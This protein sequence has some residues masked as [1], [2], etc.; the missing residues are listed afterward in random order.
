MLTIRWIYK[1]S[2]STGV[3]G[4]LP[5]ATRNL[6]SIQRRSGTLGGRGGGGVV[7]IGVRAVCPTSVMLTK[8]SSS[9]KAKWKELF[10]C[11]FLSHWASSLAERSSCWSQ[12]HVLDHGHILQRVW[13]GSLVK[14]RRQS[15][16]MHSWLYY[17][18]IHDLEQVIKQL[19]ALN[20][21]L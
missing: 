16:W 21:S 10:L 13:A 4:E 11:D 5:F 15:A 12:C 9:Q 6:H 1:L 14:F 7:P 2:L 19:R 3:I 20:S 17:H 8:C 18:L